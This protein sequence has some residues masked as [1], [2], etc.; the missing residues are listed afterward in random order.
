[1][2]NTAALIIMII[3]AIPLFI[4]L[5]IWEALS[6]IWQWLKDFKRAIQ[7]ILTFQA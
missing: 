2:Y 4:I 3:I 7:N 1:M 5:G 6:I